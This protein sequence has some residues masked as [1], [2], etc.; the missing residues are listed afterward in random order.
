[1]R[2]LVKTLLG[3]GDAHIPQVFQR[4]LFGGLALEAL[5]QLHGLHDLVA[6]GLH[7]SSAEAST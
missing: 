4:L 2:V 5:M 7:T 1:M 6:D 3:V